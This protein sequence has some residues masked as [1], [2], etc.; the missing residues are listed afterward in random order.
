[1]SRSSSSCCG[2]EFETVTLLRN[3]QSETSRVAPTLGNSGAGFDFSAATEI[4]EANASI[5]SQKGKYL[6]SRFI[7]RNFLFGGDGE[8]T[9]IG[10]RREH[11]DHGDAD[12]RAD[13]I[14]LIQAREVVEK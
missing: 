11:G 9:L 8:E 13:A 4:P 6:R 5:I 7:G 3:D 10:Q 2:P 1:M 14:E 12:Q